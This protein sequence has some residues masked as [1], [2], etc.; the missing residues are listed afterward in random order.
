MTVSEQPNGTHFVAGD[1]L[2]ITIELQ[3]EFGLPIH[4]EELS[5]ARLIISEPK[6]V[7]DTPAAVGLLNTP[8]GRG[9]WTISFL[10][11]LA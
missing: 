4:A 7:L 5:Q 9:G 11:T 10:E 1:R 6:N 2:G 8:G 3:D